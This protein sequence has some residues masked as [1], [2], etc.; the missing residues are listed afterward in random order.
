MPQADVTIFVK[1]ES[2]PAT[3]VEFLLTGPGAF[4]SP[5]T[6]PVPPGTVV[7]DFFVSPPEWKGII[8]LT[9]LDAALFTII[10]PTATPV[11]GN[12]GLAVGAAGLSEAR[13]YDVVGT[14]VP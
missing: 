12:A 7:G 13:R 4:G 6:L 8:E 10:P 2:P 9:G 1:E 11:P 14:A 5:F 3:S